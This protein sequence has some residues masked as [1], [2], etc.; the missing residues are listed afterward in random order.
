MINPGV[1]LGEAGQRGRRV[2]P[3]RIDLLCNVS[4]TG[5]VN[6]GVVGHYGGLEG[7]DRTVGAGLL[8]WYTSLE[9]LVVDHC[10]WGRVS[11]SVYTKAFLSIGRVDCDIIGRSSVKTV[12]RTEG[13]QWEI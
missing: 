5:L 3:V 9:E 11:C 7:R 13:R 1:L 4:T 6:S 8:S 10:L 12:K 2:F